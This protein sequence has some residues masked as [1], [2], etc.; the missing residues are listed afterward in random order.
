MVTRQ[1]VPDFETLAVPSN[2]MGLELW[3]TSATSNFCP[4]VSAEVSRMVS[5]AA[6]FI[7]KL[8]Q[9]MSLLLR[10]DAVN[11]TRNIT[12]YVAVL[13][14]HPRAALRLRQLA[15]AG[16]CQRKLGKHQRSAVDHGCTALTTEALTGSAHKLMLRLGSCAQGIRQ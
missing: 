5:I 11:G 15:S 6:G 12:Q 16:K 4:K 7:F 1:T 14:A 10:G 8:I 3:E 2:E 9:L 13:T